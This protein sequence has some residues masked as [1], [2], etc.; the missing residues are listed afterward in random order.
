LPTAI[1]A[2]ARVRSIKLVC[3]TNDALRTQ[4]G[5]TI[6][7]V[8]PSVNEPLTNK[9]SIIYTTNIAAIYQVI[10]KV[11]CVDVACKFTQSLYRAFYAQIALCLPLLFYVHRFVLLLREHS[12]SPFLFCLAPVDLS[13]NARSRPCGLRHAAMTMPACD[14]ASR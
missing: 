9:R 1:R 11:F 8:F 13:L 14:L 2:I 10:G 4:V 7:H 5:P 3:A 6:T 12:R